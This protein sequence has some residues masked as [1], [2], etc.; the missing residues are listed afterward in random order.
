MKHT[1]THEHALTD[2]RATQRLHKWELRN[3]PRGRWSGFH[4]SIKAKKS[5]NKRSF[6]S[7]WKFYISRFSF[8]SGAKP[9]R[10]PVLISG[11]GWGG[12]EVG[13]D[14]SR[15]WPWQCITHPDPLRELHAKKGC[16]PLPLNHTPPPQQLEPSSLLGLPHRSTME[17][18]CRLLS[19]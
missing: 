16:P 4:F 7:T 2:T 9:Q 19:R 18:I 14:E 11:R 5:W 6:I 3:K 15:G 17:A 8:R 13:K 1:H 10:N 12:E